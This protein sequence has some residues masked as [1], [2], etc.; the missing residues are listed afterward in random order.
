MNRTSAR[1]VTISAGQS[2]QRL[3]NFL[4]RELKGIPKSRIYKM[5]RKG[6]VRVNKGRIKPGYKLNEGDI[7][8]IPPV[9]IDSTKKTLYISDI[10][11]ENFKKSIIHEDSNLLVI[12]KPAGMPVHAGSKL[13]YG[14][15]E[16]AR[17]TFPNLE[18]IELAHRLDRYTSGVLVMAK[19]RQTLLA[20][21]AA[22]GGADTAKSYIC[23]VK[24]KWPRDLLSVDLP[25]HRD[26]SGKL[27]KTI[28]SKNG[29]KARSSMKVI[30]YYK[31]NTLLKVEIHTGRTHQIRVHTA[32]SGYPVIGDG[33]YG[34]QVTNK[35][36]ADM[37]L[38]RQF[39]HA[40][41]MQIPLNDE[42][43]V[44]NAPLAEDLDK[45][46]KQL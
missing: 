33:M 27:S 6:E 20:F 36:F 15:I 8:R 30:D 24:G 40:S 12:N 17:A 45:V 9:N 46:L 37:G 21:Q 39:L 5:F 25:L 32:A 38:G 3:D 26:R 10:N 11:K 29:K 34:D 44:F 22:L 2:G 18:N 42:T 4:L 16:V 7:V 1:K 41:F 35:R 28:V 19:N 43:F 14:V 31:N 13:S 23:L